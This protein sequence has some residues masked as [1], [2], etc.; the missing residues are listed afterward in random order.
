M[1][2][3]L[4]KKIRI[5]YNTI[6]VFWCGDHGFHL[7]ENNHWGKWKNY[8]ASTWVPLIMRVPGKGKPGTRVTGLVETIDMYQTLIDL[9]GLPEPDCELE[10]YSFAPLLDAPDQPWKTAVFSHDI[11]GDRRAVKTKQYNYIKDENGD[12]KELY[13]MIKDPRETTNIAGNNP[14]KI[15]KMEELYSAGWKKA[16]PENPIR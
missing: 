15:R 2:L 12:N 3:N 6:I 14:D 4:V 10:G 13:D 16:I 11:S 9:A 1:L 8:R 5:P 7:G